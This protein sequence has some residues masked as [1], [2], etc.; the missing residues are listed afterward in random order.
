M[1]LQKEEITQ[2]HGTDVSIFMFMLM[3]ETEPPSPLFQPHLEN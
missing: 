1:G 3:F 2:S